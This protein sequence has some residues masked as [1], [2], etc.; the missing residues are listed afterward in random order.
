LTVTEL[1]EVVEDCAI[2]TIPVSGEV[3]ALLVRAEAPGEPL[4][5]GTN[6]CRRFCVHVPLHVIV[7]A[8]EPFAPVAPVDPVD[9][10]TPVGPAGPAT[11]L[12]APLAPVGPA[13]PAAPVDPAGPVAP[14]DP[15]VPVVPVEP[16]RAT[17]LHNELPVPVGGIFPVFPFWRLTYAVPLL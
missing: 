16:P 1:P 2:P 6:C 13:A 14:I 7:I 15:A 5:N 3:E 10:V 9:P 17:R 8:A 11:L 12:G 4:L